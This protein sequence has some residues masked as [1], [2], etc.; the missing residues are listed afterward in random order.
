MVEL[1]PIGVVVVLIVESAADQ[2]KYTGCAFVKADKVFFSLFE[3]V[4]AA[5]PSGYTHE[6]GA[7][8]VIKV[9]VEI[10][11]CSVDI[12]DGDIGYKLGVGPVCLHAVKVVV[13]V[14]VGIVYIAVTLAEKPL[15][16]QIPRGVTYCVGRIVRDP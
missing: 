3:T 6:L 4:N 16:V 8:G 1:H 5:H 11:A 9:K 15:I 12:G 2:I 7:A 13:I 14:D 10:V